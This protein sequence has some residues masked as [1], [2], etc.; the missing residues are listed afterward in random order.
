MALPPEMKWDKN[1][2]KLF[3]NS[4]RDSNYWPAWPQASTLPTWP[5]CLSFKLNLS[6]GQDTI[7]KLCSKIEVKEELDLAL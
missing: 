6:Q 1:E 7:T 5:H 2:K 4:Y 3:F